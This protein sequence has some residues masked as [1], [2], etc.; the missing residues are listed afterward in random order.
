M[1]KTMK[2]AEVLDLI[3]QGVSVEDIVL[4]DLEEKRLSFRD[5]LLLVENGYL[6]SEKNM[7]YRDSDVVYDPDFEE[8]EWEGKYSNLK[9]MLSSKG[10]AKGKK[11]E[12]ITIELSIEDEA[13]REWLNNNT[14]KLKDLVNKLVTDLYHTD[15]I[16][17]SK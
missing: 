15:Q 16:L 7:L 12:V 8:V 14:A 13:V 5:A 3:R 6:V 10:I 9:D 11:E 17:H 4:S 1:K 2:T